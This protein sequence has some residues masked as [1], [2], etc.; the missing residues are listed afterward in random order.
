MAGDGWSMRPLASDVVAAYAARC[1]GESVS[2]PGLPVSYV[3]YALWQRDVLGDPADPGSVFG[4][5]L[6]FWESA[7]SGVPE[8]VSLPLDRPRPVVGSFAGAVVPVV[9]PE[10][11]FGRVS[12]AARAAGVTVFM[13]LQAGLAAV[14]ARLGAGS[15]VVVGSGVAGRRDESLDDLVGFFVNTVVVRTDV[16]GD[17][18]FGELLAR[19][20]ESS[21]A[22]F[23]HQD[24]PFELVVE[25]LNP[26]R[27]A[28]VHPLFQV[29]LVVQNAEVGRFD[30][31][32]L[33][34]AAEPVDTGTS[35]FDVTIS[36]AEVFDDEGVAVGLRGFVE[37][38]TDLFDQSTVEAFVQR[39]LAVLDA[40][41]A[42]LGVRVSE[43]PILVDSEHERLLHLASSTPHAR[44]LTPAAAEATVLDLVAGWDATLPAVAGADGR[45]SYGELWAESGRVAG[46]LRSLGVNRGDIVGVVCEPSATGIAVLLGVWRA[47]AAF[48]P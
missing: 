22:A 25:R 18:S 21:L 29:A 9:V 32:G 2:W 48:C 39:W 47:G 30:L 36:V 33:S 37:Y 19:V 34:V 31:P 45:L 13:V 5:Q 10:A 44:E 23:D 24:V 3:D 16:S 14:L 38:A 40:G 17:P 7:L 11:V 27:S 6:A 42:D 12:S 20:R 15:D 1:A 26:V 8:R 46:W 4:R 28:G 43:L 41:A 35:K